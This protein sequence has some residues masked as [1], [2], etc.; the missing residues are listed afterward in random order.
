MQLLL[1]RSHVQTPLRE[2]L[3]GDEGR[4]RK[5]VNVTELQGHGS[6][7]RRPTPVRHVQQLQRERKKASCDGAMSPRTPSRLRTNK[8]MSRESEMQRPTPLPNRGL[9]CDFVEHELPRGPQDCSRN[10][11]RRWTIGCPTAALDRAKTPSSLPKKEGAAPR[12]GPTKKNTDP[13][14]TRRPHG[15]LRKVLEGDE[16]VIV[17]WKCCVN[18]GTVEV[19]V[20]HNRPSVKGWDKAPPPSRRG[21]GD[22][23]GPWLPSSAGE[24]LELHASICD[25]GTSPT[26]VARCDWRRCLPRTEVI[27]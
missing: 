9:K 2:Q 27:E 3:T 13:P 20:V 1:R 18:V 7:A 5:G 19:K 12:A 21:L 10:R 23:C 25:E 4:S 24:R 15:F 16:V 17:I 11:G 8:L 26:D 22:L 6:I 14:E